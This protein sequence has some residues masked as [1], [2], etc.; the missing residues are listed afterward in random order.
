MR[1]RAHD[2]TDKLSCGLTRCELADKFREFRKGLGVSQWGMAKICGYKSPTPISWMET[3][4]SLSAKL[5]LK[6]MSMGF[7]L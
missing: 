7:H 5:I 2:I 6:Y 1:G 4:R 3:G